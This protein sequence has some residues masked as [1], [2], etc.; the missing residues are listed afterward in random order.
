M[1]AECPEI[2]FVPSSPSS[3]GGFKEPQSEN[4]GD[5]HYWQ[6]WH[7][8]VPFTEYR[9]HFFRFLSEFGFQS[10]P[11]MKTIEQF[12]LFLYYTTIFLA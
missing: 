12:T 1:Q 8:N 9:K 6:V 3:Y 10:F 4:A 7:G 2:S 5:N 11:S